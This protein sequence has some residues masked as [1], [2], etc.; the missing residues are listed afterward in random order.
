MKG[1][2]RHALGASA[3]PRLL[4]WCVEGLA[5]QVLLGVGVIAVVIALQWPLSERAL[6]ALSATLVFPAILIASLLGG[7][8]AGS[9]AAALGLL[10]RAISLSAAASASGETARVVNFALFAIASAVVVVIGVYLRWLL[11][12][13]RNA[14]DA[15]QAQSLHYRTLFE[16]VPEGFAICDAIRGPDG[17]LVDYTIV[18]INPALQRL[19]EVGPEVVG[20]RL[21]ASPG[22]WTRWLEVCDR[23]L[24]TGDPVVFERF[25][26]ATHLWHE[27]HVSR[28]TDT[29]MAQFF[30]DITE[31]KRSEARQAEQFDELNHRVKNNL[32]MVS[33]LL[34]LQA[35]AAPGRVRDEL[36][37]AASRVQSIA[38]VH[39]SLSRGAAVDRVNFGTYLQDLCASLRR[40]LALEE[41]TVL[42]VVAEPEDLPSDTAISLGMVVNELVTNAVKYACPRGEPGR[43]AVGFSRGPDG[44][45]LTVRDHG[46]G[47]PPE[48]VD[49]GG[50]GMHLVRSLL[51]QLGAEI[52]VENRGG[53][54][55]SI[56]IPAEHMAAQS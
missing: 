49:A 41:R 54:T 45:L 2:S 42:E 27:V 50:L 10:M 20:T 52:S 14:R 22:D 23:A 9:L 30:F 7:W 18:E 39:D 25:N 24:R 55:F 17:R 35:R 19:L 33:G 53:A 43:I 8:R 29:R 37:K 34:Q 38:E 4:G 47:L 12:R 48:V 13:L 44:F 15:M 31:R 11:R 6:G 21:T 26:R 46:E 16:T 36:L 56:N 1:V 28:L 3:A 5:W 40:S 32:A 51:E